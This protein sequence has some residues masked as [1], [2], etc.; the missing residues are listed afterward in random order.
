ML[1]IGKFDPNASTRRTFLH[2][3]MLGLTGVT[4][5]DAHHLHA[6]GGVWQTQD[7]AVIFVFLGGGMS[8]IDTFDMKPTAPAEV[9]GEFQPVSTSLPGTHV[10]ELLPGLARRMDKLAVV[11]TVA[12]ERTSHGNAAHFLLTGHDLPTIVPDNDVRHANPNVGSVVAARRGSNRRPLPPFVLVPYESYHLYHP[13]AAYLSSAAAPFCPGRP[14]DS[15]SWP[16]NKDFRVRDFQPAA[17]LDA[18]RLESRRQLRESFDALRARF[19]ADVQADAL[20]AFYAE[21]F[22]TLLSDDCREAFNIHEEPNRERYGNNRMGQSFLLARRLVEAGVTFVT[23]NAAAGHHWDTHYDHFATLKDK[24][25]PAFDQALSALIDDIHVRGLAQRVLVV[26]LGE[27]GRSPKINNGQG[28]GAPGRDHWPQ[29]NS[30]LFAG[31][32]M[33]MGQLIGATDAHAAFPLS[34]P[35]SPQDVFATIY[36]FLGI[37]HR[38]AFHDRSG[39]PVPILYGGE[40]IRELS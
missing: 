27:F 32:G 6:Q 11:R 17:G 35:Y 14:S 1:S 3:G 18:A 31:G 7:T 4:M 21:A 40:P 34:Q 36:G 15:K 26:A 28:L 9:R 16:E 38:Q 10:C 13:S 2:A 8:H 33:P 19:D 39:R 30:V 5:G 23:V 20:D 24:Q 22:Q 37:D 12:H 25:L 29:A